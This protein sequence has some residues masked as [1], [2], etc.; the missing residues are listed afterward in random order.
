MIDKRTTDATWWDLL[1]GWTIMAVIL[2][3]VQ[4]GC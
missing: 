4:W 1:A 3:A 2:A